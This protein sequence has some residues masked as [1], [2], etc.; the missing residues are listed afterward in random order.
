M[1][2]RTTGTMV[3]RLETGCGGYGSAV[4]NWAYCA[5][6]GQDNLCAMGLS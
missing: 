4:G 6:T 1:I 5:G 2:G 3:L